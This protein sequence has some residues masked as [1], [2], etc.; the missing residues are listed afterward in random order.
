MLNE[1]H[2]AEDNGA[3]MI[4]SMNQ[5]RHVLLSKLVP[6]PSLKILLSKPYILSGSP[7]ML[8][9]W[10]KLF[11]LPETPRRILLQVDTMALERLVSC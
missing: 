11:R 9:L 1:T 2:R 6:L 8:V 5:G 3:L 10:I 4:T 7:C